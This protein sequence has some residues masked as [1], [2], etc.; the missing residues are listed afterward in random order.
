M[1]FDLHSEQMDAIPRINQCML[2]AL[3]ETACKQAILEFENKAQNG[4]L[5]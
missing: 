1:I 5:T 2:W 3:S 4:Y